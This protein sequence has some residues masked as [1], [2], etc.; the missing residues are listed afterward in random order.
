MKI[1]GLWGFEISICEDYINKIVEFEGF[2]GYI[3][4]ED[5]G[6]GYN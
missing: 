4:Y 2:E 1:V 3:Q 6:Q 5:Y